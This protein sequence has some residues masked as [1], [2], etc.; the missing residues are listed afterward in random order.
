MWKGCVA[1]KTGQSIGTAVLGGGPAGLTGGL[2]PRAARAARRGLRGRRDRRGHRPDGRV[3]G[4]RFDLGGHR[5]FTKLAPVAAPLGGHARRR[6]LLA[7]APVAHLLRRPLLRLPAAGADVLGAARRRRVRA[8]RALVLRGARAP[9]GGRRDV[10]GVGRRRGSGGASTR[11]S[12]APTRRR[13]G[14]SPAPRSARSGRPSASRTSPSPTRSSRCCGC[15]ASHVTT[16][17]E[18]FRY[19]RLGPGPDVGGLPARTSR[20]RGSPSS[21]GS[22]VASIRHDGG[23]RGERRRRARTA[24]AS[25]PSTAV[26]SSI[27]LGELVA[28]ARPACRP[29]EV[30]AAARAAAL[31]RAVPGRADDRRAGAVPGQLDLPPRP[32]HARRA[33][34]E[35]R[36]LERRTWCARAPPASA[37]STS[38]SRA[39]RSGA[40]PTTRPSRWPRTSSARIGLIDPDAVIDGVRVRVPKR[41]PDVRRRLRGRTSRR[42]ASYLDGFANLKTFGRNGLHRYNNQ[43]HSMW[44]AVLATLNLARR[45]RPRRLVG[46][47]RGGVPRGGRGAADRASMSTSSAETQRRLLGRRRVER[48]SRLGRALPGRARGTASTAPRCSSASRHRAPRRRAD[49][50][51]SPRGTSARARSC[52]SSGATGSSEARGELVALTISPMVPDADWV[53]S[54]RAA[55][56]VR[57]GGRRDRAGR[58]ATARRSGGVLLP[59]QPGHAVRSPSARRST[60]PATTPPT[61]GAGSGGRRHV[62]G[63][64]LGAG[65]APRAGGARRGAAS[66]LRR[67]SSAWAALQG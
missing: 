38:A 13:S 6:A 28:V 7:P 29:S 9:R 65:R 43:D 34:A 18:R 26:L 30:L 19:P 40:C 55:L 10:R 51:R 67:C 63:R 12:S 49:A 23:A 66:R 27:P 35:L 41:L 61:G 17:I 5:F 22:A 33:G 46:E 58:W 60:C 3:D 56:P 24:G 8:L 59:L 45:R 54:L 4:Y 1:E 15:G 44:T 42:S 11:R 16:L 39:T 21:S 20:G 2:R 50:S 36:R 47:H 14:A 64:L 37:S 32:G 31:P 57:R 52:P 25:T 53:A 62:D 48:S